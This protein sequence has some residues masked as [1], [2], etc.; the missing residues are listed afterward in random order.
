MDL[1]AA[2]W[3]MKNLLDYH[4]VVPEE[5]TIIHEKLISNIAPL[6]AIVAIVIYI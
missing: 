5:R 6:M 2:T 4:I 3:S 1:D